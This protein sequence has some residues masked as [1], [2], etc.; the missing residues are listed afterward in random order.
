MKARLSRALAALGVLL[1]VSASA[2]PAEWYPIA[3]LFSG[4]ACLAVSH[5]LTPCE[6]DLRPWWKAQLSKLL[7]R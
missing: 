5:V 6:N 2:S 7:R 3:Q 4:L 1:F